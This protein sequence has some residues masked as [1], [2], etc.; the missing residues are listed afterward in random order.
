MFRAKL[1]LPNGKL[2]ITGTLAW[3][4]G[5]NDR[6]VW[7]PDANASPIEKLD[8][9]K[10][11]VETIEDISDLDPAEIRKPASPYLIV[12][13]DGHRWGVY[14]ELPVTADKVVT[15]QM[16]LKTEPRARS[17]GFVMKVNDREEDS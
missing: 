4:Q 9:A 10:D 8:V 2:G 6:I 15:K 11:S 3:L 16:A 14:K 12:R 5:E 1:V 17:A 7:Q 13:V